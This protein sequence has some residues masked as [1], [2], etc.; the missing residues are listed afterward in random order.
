MSD[1]VTIKAKTLSNRLSLTFI[2]AMLAACSSGSAH[3]EPDVGTYA[4]VTSTSDIVLPLDGYRLS[5]LEYLNIQRAVW[6][7]NGACLERFGGKYTLP[8]VAVLTDVPPFEQANERRYGLFDSESASTFGYGLR[9]DQK[10]P[11][12]GKDI[13]WNPSDAELL[14]LRG[15]AGTNGPNG[16]RV[17]SDHQGNPLPADGCGG[18]STRLLAKGGP[19]APADEALANKLSVETFRKSEADSRVRDV[20][21]KWAD[22]MVDSGYDYVSIW[23]PNNFNWPDQV[24]EKE[25]ATAK[26][27][28]ACKKKVNLVGVWLAVETAYQKEAIDAHVEELTAIQKYVKAKLVNAAKVVSGN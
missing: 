16:P 2:V 11:G 1:S 23:D 17:P 26:A 6:R 27:D 13:A 3:A 15:S 7:L 12:D 4:V 10:P 28:L 19:S 21:G 18:E 9:P 24:G 8:E 20:V 5:N 14:L 22:C 25:S